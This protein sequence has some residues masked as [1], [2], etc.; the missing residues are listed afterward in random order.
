M[1]LKNL[2]LFI[3]LALL[4]LF[5]AINWSAI[6][7]PT[8]LSL[9]FTTASAPLGLV[10]LVATAL[11]FV[12]FLGYLVYWQSSILMARQ[13]LIKDLEIQRKL[14]NDAESSRFT[15]LR[16]YLETELKQLHTQH[17]GVENKIEMRI[18]ELESAVKNSVEETGTTLSAYI[19]ELGDRLDKK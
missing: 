14:A 4:I 3:A 2:L 9:I 16:N 19:G 6:M 8:E 1:Q 5:S 13:K 12:F 7:M 10:L 17:A 15:E 18:G 11:M